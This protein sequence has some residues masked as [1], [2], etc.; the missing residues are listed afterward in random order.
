MDIATEEFSHLEIVGAT[1]TMLLDGLNGQLKNAAERSELMNLLKGKSEKE[2][3]VHAAMTNPQFLVLSGGSPPLSN[4][5]GVPWPVP[6]CLEIKKGAYSAFFTP[7]QPGKLTA[8]DRLC[9]SMLNLGFLSH[10]P[11]Q[12]RINQFLRFKDIAVGDHSDFR[13]EHFSTFGQHAAINRIE[14][15]AFLLL[16]G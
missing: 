1:I 3:M 15:V 9:E 4:S 7:L 13:D 8:N 12:G 6:I 14:P 11:G 16:P 2:Q 5:Q 10:S